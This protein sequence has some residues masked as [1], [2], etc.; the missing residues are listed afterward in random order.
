M[1]ATKRT[2]SE[3]KNSFSAKI[4]S[5]STIS[6]VL[7]QCDGF[8][9]N[10]CVIGVAYLQA[11]YHCR[12]VLNLNRDSGHTKGSRYLHELAAITKR[13]A[14]SACTKYKH[15]ALVYSED[16]SLNPDTSNFDKP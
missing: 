16:G 12:I 6:C 1:Q 4:I 8:M 14:S 9:E 3:T 11:G 5:C 13:L 10:Y 15:R 7:R 2:D